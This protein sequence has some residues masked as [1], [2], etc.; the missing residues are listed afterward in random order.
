MRN[1]LPLATALLAVLALAVSALAVETALL[2]RVA[3]E[4]LEIVSV[5]H[6]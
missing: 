2:L 6:G 5:A 4:I 1:S 3:I